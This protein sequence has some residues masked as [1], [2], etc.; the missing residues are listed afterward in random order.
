MQTIAKNIAI[1]FF[2]LTFLFS[3]AGILITKHVCISEAHHLFGVDVVAMCCE[4][5]AEAHAGAVPAPASPTPMQGSSVIDADGCCVTSFL[6]VKLKDS[7]TAVN[8]QKIK[9][10][11]WVLVLVSIP[12][13]TL[14][15]EY[16]TKYSYVHYPFRL[17][18]PQS[19]L[20][21][22]QEFLK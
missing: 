13:V 15:R 8:L 12:L 21:L 11:F 20:L 16:R 3:S 17:L 18:H 10:H 6:Y 22:K 5:D 7:F 14:L 19:I 2:V 1:G 9:E 4:H